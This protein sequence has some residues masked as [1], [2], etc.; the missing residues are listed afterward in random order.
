MPNNKVKN[1]KCQERHLPL[2]GIKTKIMCSEITTR[3][4]S[5]KAKTTTGRHTDV[6]PVNH[7]GRT[8]ENKQ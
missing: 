4:G 1:S 7:I 3:K 2:T 8:I 5:F 6:L